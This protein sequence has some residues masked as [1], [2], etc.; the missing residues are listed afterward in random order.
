MRIVTI[1]NS[2]NIWIAPFM[3]DYVESE[4]KLIT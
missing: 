1:K 2:G 3:C 4:A